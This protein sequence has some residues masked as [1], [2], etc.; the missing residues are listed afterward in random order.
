MRI[1]LRVVLIALGALLLAGPGSALAA[2]TGLTTDQGVV[3]SVSPTAIV[4]RSLD[5][6]LL[7]LAVGPAT[8]VKLNG[9]PAQ[10]GDVQ[11]GFVAAVVHRGARPAVVVRAF[12]KVA[13]VTDRGIVTSLSS[14]SIA[15]R[16]ASGATLSIPLD[17]ST[18]FRRLGLPVARAAARPG[19][20]VEV[21][22]PAE[23]PARVVRVLKRG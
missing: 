23:G 13:L 10:L 7:T 21:V 11:P 22:H 8:R 14:V 9:S 5:G 19:A 3:Q 20:L 12:G 2:P 18:R 17:A 16:T 1:A 6:T 4:L 15:I